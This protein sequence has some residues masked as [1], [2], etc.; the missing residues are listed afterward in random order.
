[1]SDA[2]SDSSSEYIP[3]C[4]CYSSDGES[5]STRE[6]TR[7]WREEQDRLY[8]TH[9]N[10]D[11]FEQTAENVLLSMEKW[12]A[13]I[14][15]VRDEFITYEVC[16][17]A[18]D[19]DNSA[20]QYIKRKLLTEAEY[21]NLCLHAVGYNGWCMRYIPSDVQTQELCDV[22]VESICWALQY[23][24]DEYKTYENCMSAVGRNGQ[25]LTHVPQGFIDMAMCVAAVESKYECLD[26][27]PQEFVTA[28]LC[29]K[30]VSAIGENAKHVPEEYMSVE[31]AFIAIRT[32]APCNPSGDMAASNVRFI[33]A[34]YITWDL[35]LEA[36]RK[37]CPVYGWIPDVH[38]TDE[39]D[40]AVLDTTPYC[41]RYMK[42]TP[43]KCMRALRV[44][45]RVIETA[46]K[47]ESLTREMA[48]Y[49]LG[50]PRKITKYMYKERKEV[51]K[52]IV[53]S[54]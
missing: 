30:A 19:D 22:A 13:N 26:M 52:S 46:I 16:K 28:E 38:K 47:E 1:M 5:V 54:V 50:L 17:A 53:S 29:H 48:E 33:P 34:K 25:I 35:A 4:C 20:L 27:I 12:G 45:Y 41:I 21:Y 39:F 44:N 37:W 42:Q 3:C 31:L 32:P 7:A 49:V 6:S 2:D 14:Q 8:L 40:N 43:E 9:R 23:V 11:T 36:V 24:R 10:K 51:L 15:Y 18:I